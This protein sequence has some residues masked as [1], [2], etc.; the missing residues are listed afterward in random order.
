MLDLPLLGSGFSHTDW[1][2][3]VEFWVQD[4]TDYPKPEAEVGILSLVLTAESDAD[5][6]CILLVWGV[7]F[8]FSAF[9]AWE[10][11]HGFY[12]FMSYFSTPEDSSLLSLKESVE[13]SQS[14]PKSQQNH[15]RSG[16]SKLV[17]SIFFYS[18][19]KKINERRMFST[20]WLE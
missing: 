19:Y 5:S 12:L 3:N 13:K 16:K 9:L 8:H 15:F 18:T 20:F 10:L 2:L 7:L 11:L 6:R 14:P 4:K 1:C 17:H